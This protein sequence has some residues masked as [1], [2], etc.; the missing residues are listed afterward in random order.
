[1]MAN[2]WG[3]DGWFRAAFATYDLLRRPA[4]AIP[5]CMFF[6][7]SFSIYSSRGKVGIITWMK[8]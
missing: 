2:D 7:F 5:L 3:V 4:Y 6:F 1:M 8:S